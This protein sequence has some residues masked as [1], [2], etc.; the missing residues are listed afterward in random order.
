MAQP[1]VQHEAVKG[2]RAGLRNTAGRVDVR[3]LSSQTLHHDRTNFRE[4]VTSS[5]Q[6]EGTISDLGVTPCYCQIGT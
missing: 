2:G 6:A 1:P 4:Q 3:H 5:N